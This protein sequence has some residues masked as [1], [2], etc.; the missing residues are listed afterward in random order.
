M[1]LAHHEVNIHR[2]PSPKFAT[3][4]SNAFRKISCCGL[5]LCIQTATDT[6]IVL[7]IL[8][9]RPSCA[10]EQGG[11]DFGCDGRLCQQSHSTGDTGSEFVLSN[12]ADLRWLSW[13]WQL[14]L[15][16]ILA[17]YSSLNYTVKVFAAIA[18]HPPAPALPTVA[19]ARLCLH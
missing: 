10:Q 6:I 19:F 18:Q 15:E 2:S 13:G 3:C 8:N 1:N 7:P 17:I 12:Q 9:R 4:P 14:P 5:P 11:V 16:D